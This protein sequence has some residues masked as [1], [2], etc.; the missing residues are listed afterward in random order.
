MVANECLN[1]N[2]IITLRPNRS[3]SWR[4]DREQIRTALTNAGLSETVNGG[5]AQS[6]KGCWWAE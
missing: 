5:L 1:G 6:V 3:A 4:Q 2:T